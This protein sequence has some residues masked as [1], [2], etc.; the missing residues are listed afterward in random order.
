MNGSAE[1]PTPI[2]QSRRATLEDLPELRSLWHNARLDLNDLE[3]RFTEFQ[4][5]TSPE[6]NIVGAVG[7]QI[8]KHHGLIHSETYTAPD[9]AAELRPL[10]WQRILTVAKNNGLVRLW[11][12]P[13]ASFY[14]EQGFTDVDDALR[15]K[16]PEPFGNP[17]VD[18][19]SLKLKEES[20]SAANI[21]REFEIFAMAQKQESERLISQAKSFKV[22]A[23][24]LLFL[25]LGAI[26]VLAFVFARIRNRRGR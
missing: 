15:A 18:W 8:H 22:L 14:R 6:G 19:V 1:N 13:V 20:Q 12:L 3:K 7:L 11:T 23:Y 9:L 4:L 10:L 16:L 24:G 25:V 26:A 2:Y 17:K 5:V 21:E